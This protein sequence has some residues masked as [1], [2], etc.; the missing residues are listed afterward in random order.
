MATQKKH[1]AP[2]KKQRKRQSI[3]FSSD[4]GTIAYVLTDADGLKRKKAA[5][6][7]VVEESFK[8]CS[9]VALK[10]EAWKTGQRLLVKVGSLSPMMAEVRWVKKYAGKFFHLG[11]LFLE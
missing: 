10:D 1:S 11:L 2:V 7:L 9:L 8:G 4:P 3:R 6:A 5:S